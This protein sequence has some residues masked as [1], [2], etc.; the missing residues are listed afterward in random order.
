[1]FASNCHLLS[2]DAGE[3]LVVDPGADADQI[4][5]AIAGGNLRVA[6][7]LLTHGH[8][9]HVSALAEVH[10]KHP[11]PIAMHPEDSKWAFSP[12]NKMEPFFSQPEAPPRIDREL[13]DGQVCEDIGFTYRVIETPGHS[14][15]GV[16]FYFEDQ[17]VLIAGDTLF[18][19]SVGRVDLP[20]GN[21]QALSRS[22]QKLCRLPYDTVVY[23]GHGPATTIGAEKKTNYFLRPGALG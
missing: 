18:R 13:A 7:Y 10:R 1:M 17:G 5:S 15:G 19:G 2:N 23:C 22:L 20:G 9:D 21:G 16:C 8:V 3:A 14:P 11:A 6:G 4:L 12:G